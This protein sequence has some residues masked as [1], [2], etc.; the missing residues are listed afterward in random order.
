L[1]GRANAGNGEI[2]RDSDCWAAPLQSLNASQLRHDPLAL[3]SF[4][5]VLRDRFHKCIGIRSAT[6][7]ASSR[8]SGPYRRMEVLEPAIT[9]GMTDER[10]RDCTDL[11]GH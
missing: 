7:I 3:G 11:C 8:S 10:R 9:G 4:F 5:V 1:C 2:G 6:V